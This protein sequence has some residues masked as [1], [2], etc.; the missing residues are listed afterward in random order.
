MLHKVVYKSMV[1]EKFSENVEIGILFIL[2]QRIFFF[3]LH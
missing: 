2:T 3:E 1:Y